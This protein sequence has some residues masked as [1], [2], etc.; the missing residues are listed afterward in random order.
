MMGPII[1][2]VYMKSRVYGKTV[3]LGPVVL[4]AKSISSGLAVLFP[5][6]ISWESVYRRGILWLGI[7]NFWTGFVLEGFGL[8]RFSTA[9]I[10][11]TTMD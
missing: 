1:K 4:M 9:V 6:S 11:K 5:M 8:H 10:I 7:P 2:T 3:A